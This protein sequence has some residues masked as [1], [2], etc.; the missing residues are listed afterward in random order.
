MRFGR[1]FASVPAEQHPEHYI[2][3]KGMSVGQLPLVER[4]RLRVKGPELVRVGRIPAFLL[5]IDRGARHEIGYGGQRWCTLGFGRQLG[6]HDIPAPQRHAEVTDLN[7]IQHVMWVC[8][9]GQRDSQL[10]VMQ[11]FPS[12]SPVGTQPS[13][14]R[15]PRTIFVPSS[16][17]SLAPRCVLERGQV[18]DVPII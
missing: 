14:C 13:G 16:G 4:C 12:S 8:V 7:T 9:L 17:E 5:R 2:C 10:F 3:I 11:L 1:D 6:R 15:R 18:D